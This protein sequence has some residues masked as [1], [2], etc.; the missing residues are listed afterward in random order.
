MI[1]E[2]HDGPPLVQIDRLAVTFYTPRGTVRA[3]RDAS[4]E[5][6]RGEVV[7]LVGESGCGKSTTARSIIRADAGGPVAPRLPH[8]LAALR[9]PGD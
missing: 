8:A 7:G 1:E 6:R 5:I 3:V 2:V 4:L 9:D